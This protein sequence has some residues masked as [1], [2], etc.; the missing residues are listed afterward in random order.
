MPN[1]K[2]ETAKTPNLS[3]LRLSVCP[4]ELYDISVI[5]L[6]LIVLVE[7]RS[8]LLCWTKWSLKLLSYAD[9]SP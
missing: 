3:I 4:K 9:L 5:S 2:F 8:S 7:K 6:I 1:R